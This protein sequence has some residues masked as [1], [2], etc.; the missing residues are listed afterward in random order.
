MANLL[1]HVENLKKFGLPVVVAINRFSAD[2]DTEIAQVK[3]GRKRA[4]RRSPD[5]RPLG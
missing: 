5:G 3:D 1:R 2:T 4:R